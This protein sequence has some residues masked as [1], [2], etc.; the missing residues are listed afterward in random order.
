MIPQPLWEKTRKMMIEQLKNLEAANII[1][2]K[3]VGAFGGDMIDGEF[4]I[5][6]KVEPSKLVE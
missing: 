6:F 5:K 3:T 4:H 1:E 2:C